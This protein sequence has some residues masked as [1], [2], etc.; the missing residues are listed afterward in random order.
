MKAV[1]L[2]KIKD[3][4]IQSEIQNIYNVLNKIGIG[5]IFNDRSENMDMYLIEATANANPGQNTQLTHD[6]KRT[7]VGYLVLSQSGSGDFY[8][9][10]GTNSNTDFYIKCTTA[11]TRFKIA[12][13]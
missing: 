6:L 12:L 13:L 11:S 1:Q 2:R 10:S 5:T 4:D 7:P 8:E 9:G 3:I